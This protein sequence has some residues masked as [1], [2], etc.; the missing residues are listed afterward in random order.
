MKYRWIKELQQ[1]WHLESVWIHRNCLRGVCKMDMEMI[2]LHVWPVWSGYD[3]SLREQHTLF[4]RSDGV[5]QGRSQALRCLRISVLQIPEGIA[6][7]LWSPVCQILCL[8]LVEVS[9]SV[10]YSRKKEGIKISVRSE[11]PTLDAGKIISKALKGI[12]SGGGHATMAGGFV[13][14]DGNDREEDLM[15]QN[16]RE[17]FIDVI[18]RTKRKSLR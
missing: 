9:F 12:G 11:R 2:W 10:V 18:S 8:P 3:L 1:R 17:R 13:P 15:I 16:I 5:F 4:W 7:R 6:R 14:F